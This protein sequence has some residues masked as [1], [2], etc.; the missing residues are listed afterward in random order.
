MTTKH[1]ELTLKHDTEKTQGRL[2]T[3]SQ[4]QKSKHKNITKKPHNTQNLKL[5]YYQNKGLRGTSRTLKM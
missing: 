1:S 4:R 3:Q 5:K 2:Q